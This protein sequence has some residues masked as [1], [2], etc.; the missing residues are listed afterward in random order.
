MLQEIAHIRVRLPAWH[1][2]L[3]LL[4]AFGS[5]GIVTAYALAPFVTRGHAA[6]CIMLLALVAGISALWSP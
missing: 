6:P 5:V 1:R 4:M 2:K 3:V